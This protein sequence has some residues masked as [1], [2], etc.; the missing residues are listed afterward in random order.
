MAKWLQ[1]TSHPFYADPPLLA[2]IQGVGFIL[3]SPQ[4]SRRGASFQSISQLSRRAN[5]IR[6]QYNIPA[7]L[8]PAKGRQ[9]N[10][11]YEVFGGRGVYRASQ[12]L[13]VN[14]YSWVTGAEILYLIRD[15][16]G[17]QLELGARA[18]RSTTAMSTGITSPFLYPTN[19]HPSRNTLLEAGYAHACPVPPTQWYPPHC[20]TQYRFEALDAIGGLGATNEFQIYIADAA[21]Y[22]PVRLSTLAFHVAAARTGGVLPDSF[23]VCTSGVRGYPKAFCGTDAQTLQV[24][25]RLSEAVPGPLHFV[26]FTETAASRIRGG[27]QVFALPAFQWHAD[28]GI[29]LIYRG[30]RLDY[31]YGTDGGRLTFELQGQSF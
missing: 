1:P 15:T 20:Y 6:V 14:I 30:F 3:T 28:S 27:S 21:Q 24:E 4:T 17:T 10:F 2:P 8:N 29:G 18:Q 23:L 5:L 7:Y 13:A 16:R 11:L 9:S 22:I 31:A 19:L 12:P 26:L 25:Y